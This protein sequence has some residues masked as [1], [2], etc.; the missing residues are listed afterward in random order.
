MSVN[1]FSFGFDN[2]NLIYSFLIY[3]ALLLTEIK[4][5]SIE[6]QLFSKDLSLSHPLFSEIRKELWYFVKKNT[7]KRKKKKNFEDFFN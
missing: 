7:L 5:Y 2:L 3:I 1:D 6:S 4:F